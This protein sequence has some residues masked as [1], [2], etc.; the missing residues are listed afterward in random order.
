MQIQFLKLHPDAICPKQNNPWEAWFDLHSI[1][2]YNL[3]PW[4]RKLFKTGIAHAL[5]QWYYGRIAGRSGLW[6]KYGIDV[7]AGVIDETYR[8]DIGI[9]VLN[10]WSDI[11]EVKKWDRIAQ[12]II[13]QYFAPEWI[14]VTELPE[15]IRWESW[16]WGS[17]R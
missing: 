12:Y 2:E 10:T 14:E 7:L 15:S 11:L 9:V 4:E 8:W 5:P 16:F 6:Y 17:G 1:E 3:Q 13:E